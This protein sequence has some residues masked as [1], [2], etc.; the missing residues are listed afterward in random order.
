MNK[1]HLENAASVE[2]ASADHVRCTKQLVQIADKN[3]RFRS[4]LLKE[5]PCIVESV[6]QNTENIEME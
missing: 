6:I 3:V 5:G 4:N 1:W 2:A